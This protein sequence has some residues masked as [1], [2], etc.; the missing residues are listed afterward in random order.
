ML[1]DAAEPHPVLI[2]GGIERRSG[3]YAPDRVL[4]RTNEPLPPAPVAPFP[5]NASRLSAARRFAAEVA[6]R[7]GLDGDRLDDFVL[8]I[9]ELTANSVRHGGGRGVLRLAAAA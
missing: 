9:G 7:A 2:E 1:A 5:F 3:D 4:D 8:A 6:K